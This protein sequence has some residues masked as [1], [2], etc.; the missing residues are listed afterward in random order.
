MRAIV[1]SLV[2]TRKATRQASWDVSRVSQQSDGGLDV[3]AEVVQ[4]REK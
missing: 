1:L 4:K 3:S 2:I